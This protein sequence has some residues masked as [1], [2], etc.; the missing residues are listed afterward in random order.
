MKCG[1]PRPLYHR[2]G[3]HK[4]RVHIV[5]APVGEVGNG[6]RLPFPKL[7]S[8]QHPQRVIRLLDVPDGA[9]LRHIDPKY[10]C[11]AP[12]ILAGPFPQ[13]EDR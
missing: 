3:G 4:P 2:L 7:T 13:T 8:S 5:T 1:S 12:C 6:R 11:T 10:N 9:N